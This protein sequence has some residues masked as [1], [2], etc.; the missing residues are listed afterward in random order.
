MA[1]ANFFNKSALAAS[2]VLNGYDRSA[3]ETRLLN[4]PVEIAFDEQAISTDEGKA[5]LEL[6][7]RLL[8]R[9]YPELILTGL[10]L[11]DSEHVA[12]LRELSQSINPAI[13]FEAITPVITVVIGATKIDRSSS[14]IYIGSDGWVVKL[15]PQDPVASGNSCNPFA[16]GAAACFGA[17]NVFR[18]IFN[19]QLDAAD[20]DLPFSMSLL[21]YDRLGQENL[22]S[23]EIDD[24]GSI[25]LGVVT[26]VGIGA[27][28]NGVVWALSKLP[29]L[30]GELHLVDHEKVDLSNLQRY[31]LA[32][33]QDIDNTKSQLGKSQ[34]RHSKLNI[35]PYNGN[36]AS[37]LNSGDHWNLDMVL[38]AVDSSRDRIA[39][40]GALPKQVLNAW[41]QPGDLGISRHLNFLD[42]ACLN[43]LYPS[44]SAAKSESQL[45][46]ESFGLAHEEIT[47]RE[48]LY[49][50]A[51][52]DA[53]WAEKIAQA[54]NIPIDLL[55]P[56]LGQPIRN[57]YHAVF[58]GG[59]LIGHEQNQKVETPMAFQSAL[60][61]ILLASELVTIKG[62]FRSVPIQTMT[63]INLLR[64]ITHYINEPLRKSNAQNC[65]CQ[66]EDFRAQYRIKHRP[67]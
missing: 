52:V 55:M 12:Q 62:G 3:F 36:W 30:K 14:V 38:A 64:P 44:K 34:F 61:G 16:A 15:S 32:G 43:C 1:L 41:T 49:N 26:L 7:V 57:F 65:I 63:R 9:L 27:I 50:N 31:I 67:L 58:C 29:I 35:H 21:N 25:N 13:G 54:K 4:S 56:H 28:G 45:I 22:V 40:Q 23:K 42:E 24:S 11:K 37:Y 33:Q 17:A 8:A 59:I 10:A 48:L 2:Q 6:T 18:L 20:M 66:D 53:Y 19:D 46:S 39:I 5:T 47:I 51:V 60:A